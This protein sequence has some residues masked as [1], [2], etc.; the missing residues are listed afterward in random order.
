MNKKQKTGR[1][2][3]FK[4]EYCDM[5]VK[6]MSQGLS[7]ESFGAQ[8][9]VCR[10]TLYEWDRVHPNFSYA[11]KIG[12]LK[13]LEVLEKIGMQGMIGKIKGFNVASW[14]FTC[15]NRHPDMFQDKME[16]GQDQ[17]KPF[18]LNYKLDE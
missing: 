6:H 4:E 15:K 14:I 10:D 17:L 11:K 13:S 18:T 16:L 7:F 12:K 5:L 2:S 9:S 8:L 1:P 3:K